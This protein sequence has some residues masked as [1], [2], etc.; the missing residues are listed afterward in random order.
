M[1]PPTA[2]L[3][4]ADMPAWNEQERRCRTC[5][6]ILPITSFYTHPDTGYTQRSC[7]NCRRT[8]AASTRGTRGTRTARFAARMTGERVFGVEMEL[9][10][11]D[12]PT[13]IDALL[14]A[15]IRMNSTNE[16]DRRA[17][18]YDHTN[19][20]SNI[21]TLKRDGSVSGFALELVSPKLSGSAGF[22]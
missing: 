11:P 9:T 6:E 2:D 7:R 17:L 13:I 3:K 16:R 14:R 5:R 1:R 20:E 12:A 10:G 15:G 18:Q 4:E 22:A 8:A 21:W 19:T